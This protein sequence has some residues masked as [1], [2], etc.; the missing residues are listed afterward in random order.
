MR[1][2]AAFAGQDAAR[3]EEAC[4]VLGLGEWTDED[5]G[6]TGLRGLLRGWR[7]EHDR[8]LRGA[9]RGGHATREHLELGVAVEGGVEQ[10]VELGGVDRQY[11]L[12]LVEQPLRD[13]VDG[14]ANGG[15]GRPLRVAR[16]Q[17]VQA[18]LFD[19]ELGVLHVAVDP[20]EL[21]HDLDEAL[22]GLRHHLGEFAQLRRVAH[23]AD[24][25]LA[26]CVD[27]EVT[28]W[29]WRP[30]NLVAT[31]GDARARV[32]ATVAEDHLLHVDRRAPVVGDLVDPPVGDS[33]CPAPGAEH[34]EHRLVQLHTRVL[35]KV[36]ACQRAEV[37]LERGGQ[38]LQR[39]DVELGVERHATLALDPR[40]LTL[41][42]LGRD[43]V[44]DVREHLH[45]APV[46][47]PGEALVTGHA[48]EAEDRLVGQSQVQDGV[49]HAWH[50]LARARAD[51]Q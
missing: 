23:A 28:R 22:I 33:A 45:E 37:R 11:R 1:R 40:D 15:L 31:E 19:R 44:D 38:L 21:A 50:R 6:L 7:A 30:G 32:C 51:R 46:R 26:L 43:A 41:E 48:R 34:G 12:R 36:L 14:E 8:P 4:D 35:R 9:R 13:R 20:L 47:V 17:H 18:A 27:Q 29:R 42:P 2:L 39:C 49:H 10:R 3:G 25:V 24:H 16:L 5:H